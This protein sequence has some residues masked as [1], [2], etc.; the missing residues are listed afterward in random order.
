MAAEL[1]YAWD[2]IRDVAAILG[3]GMAFVLVLLALAMYFN[4]DDSE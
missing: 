2:L 3:A 4:M 1:V